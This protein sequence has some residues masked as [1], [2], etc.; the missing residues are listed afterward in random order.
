MYS[1]SAIASKVPNENIDICNSATFYN[2]AVEEMA[3]S[4]FCLYLQS[5][6]YFW[7]NAWVML[8]WLDELLMG[9]K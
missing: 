6:G 3:Q 5:L 1:I 2:S 8:K 7:L 9:R 4:L